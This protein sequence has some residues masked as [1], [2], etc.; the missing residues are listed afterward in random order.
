MTNITNCWMH[1]YLYMRRILY[2][3]PTQ[4][5]AVPATQCSARGGGR[6]NMLLYNDRIN[7]KIST[8]VGAGHCRCVLK[9]YVGVT[10]YFIIDSQLLK[11]YNIK[12][13]YNV[14]TKATRAA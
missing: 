2:I 11:K 4:I 3:P 12:M 14:A 1:I 5:G 6:G 7:L 13:T 8:W 10:N 9:D